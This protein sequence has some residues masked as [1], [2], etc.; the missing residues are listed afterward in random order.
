MHLTLRTGLAEDLVLDLYMYRA[1]LPRLPGVYVV[2]A[3]SLLG[4]RVLYVGQAVDLDDR[5]GRGLSQHEHQPDFDA[6]GA[7]HIGVWTAANMLAIDAMEDHLIKHYCP[8]INKRGNPLA[9]VAYGA[10]T[11][12]LSGD[13]FR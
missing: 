5:A 2:M 13:L 3:P 7:T 10:G 8:P 12:L 4:P 9:A 11:R 1:H 6:N